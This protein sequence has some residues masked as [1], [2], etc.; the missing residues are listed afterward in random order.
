MIE[1]VKDKLFIGGDWVEPIDGEMVESIDPAT[2]TPWA[3][4]AFGG[5]KDMDR[6]VDA[7]REAM[8]GPWRKLPV[9][10]RAALLRRF[11]EIYT[12]R[13]EELAIIETRDTGRPIRDTKPDFAMQPQ[14][15]WWYAALADKLTGSTIPMDPSMHVFTTRVPV[16]VVGAITA[17]NA[18]MFLANLKLAPAL[19]AGCAVILKP[20]ETTPV[21]AY[22]IA[23]MAIEAGFPPGVVNVVPSTG[24]V[25]GAHLVAHPGVDKISFTGGA[26]TAKMMLAAG[27]PTL[28]R[29]TF[30]LGGK[31]P[32]IIFE[33]ADLPNA[34]N[35]ATSSAWVV[36]G[37]SCALGSRVLVQRSI[38]H[39]VVRQFAERAAQVRVGLPM[40][41]RTHMGPQANSRQLDKTLSYFDIGRDE[42]ARLVTGGKRLIEGDLRQGF[43]VTPTVFADVRNDM[44]IAREE[45]FGPVASLIPFDTE[46]EAVAIANDTSYGLTAGLWTR[47]VSRAH[48]VAEQIE[49]GSVWVNTYRFI[50]W[51]VPYGGMKHSGWGREGGMQA[52]DSYLET[53]ATAIR[54]S[55]DFPNAYAN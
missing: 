53:K 8:R 50:R 12:R 22:E 15:W 18:P 38:Y 31:A 47:D 5:V 27:A 51:S 14:T 55:G 46:S 9:W 34:V 2:N 40:D 35:A 11:A 10:E 3:K 36:C 13:A 21:G 29:F 44:R 20:A 25:G 42:G 4:V 48:R 24:P 7:A 39:E 37:Q 26:A 23:K 19:A 49:S 43:F 52:L 45:I 6:A 33:D 41:P 16:G 54:L 17:W 1:V 28:K 32:H 30:E